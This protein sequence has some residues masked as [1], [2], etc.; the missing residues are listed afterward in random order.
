MASFIGWDVGGA[1]LKAAR[2]EGTTLR[3]VIQLPCTLWLGP[4][5]LDR[6][7]D[8]ALSQLGSAEGHA[9]TMTGE[10][11]DYFSERAEGVRRLT[12]LLR[13]RLPNL[14]IWAGPLG[15]LGAEAAQNEVRAVASANWLA[16]VTWTARRL[17]QGLFA[18]MGS[19]T[20][21]LVPFTEGASRH[22]GFTDAERLAE[23][24]LVYTG[25][26]RTPLMAVAQTIPF[27][28][29]TQGVM[30]EYFATIADAHRLRG[31]L[32]DGIDL[33]DTADRRGKS[34]EES[35]A[36]IARMVGCD[37]ADARME[38]WCA[39]A[40]SFA[41]R[42][43][44]QLVEAAERVL[45]RGDLDRAAPVVGAGAGRFVLR[46]LAAALGRPYRDFA[47]IIEGAPELREAAAIAAP[48]AAVGL[49]AA[50]MA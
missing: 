9:V 46:E 10:L 36:R 43:L 20:T 33:H 15:F 7:L 35:A 22:H 14:R 18:D 45:S 27:A 3:Q 42:Q 48:A 21:D 26:V 13:E 23:V 4:E 50:S 30:A 5:H 16:T 24:E 12:G 34:V 2:I 37:L 40:E 41:R 25:A 8:H 47:E 1:H 17:P 11:V 39:L 28:G 31:V 38:E 6:A 32:P 44:E 49:L 29:Q 19:T